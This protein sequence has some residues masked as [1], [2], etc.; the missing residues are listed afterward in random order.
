MRT[1][2]LVS[3][4]LSV[5]PVSKSTCKSAERF[6]HTIRTERSIFCFRV[7]EIKPRKIPVNRLTAAAPNSIAANG[8]IRNAPAKVLTT[9]ARVQETAYSR[10]ERSRN[11]E[12]VPVPNAMADMARADAASRRMWERGHVMYAAITAVRP[13]T[14]DAESMRRI[15][16]GAPERY[17]AA[18]S[19]AASGRA[20]TAKR[21]SR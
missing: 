18:Q 9:P 14:A 10:Q 20:L 17:P 12:R 8:R 15:F 13:P 21:I 19:R 7:S 1:G 16:K 4:D 6:P 5:C 3:G 2:R 11:A